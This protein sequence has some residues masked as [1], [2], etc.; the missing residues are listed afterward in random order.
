MAQ[1][2]LLLRAA[3]SCEFSGSSKREVYHY[4][5]ETNRATNGRL[6]AESEVLWDEHSWLT[7]HAQQALPLLSPD[8]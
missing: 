1:K 6:D 7:A 8:P 5:G 3:L 2:T 4:H